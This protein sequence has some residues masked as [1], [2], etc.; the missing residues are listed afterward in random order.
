MIINWGKYSVL[1]LEWK[2]NRWAF[3]V[4]IIIAHLCLAYWCIVLNFMKLSYLSLDTEFIHLHV[5]YTFSIKSK[6]YW[7]LNN[8]LY[9]W[10]SL[11]YFVNFFYYNCHFARMNKIWKF[12]LLKTKLWSIISQKPCKICQYFR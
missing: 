2:C 5:R 9:S 1:F 10:L 4:N 3:F 12:R 11:T 8:K 7:K 6:I